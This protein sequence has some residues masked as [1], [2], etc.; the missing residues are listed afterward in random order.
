MIRTKNKN[1]KKTLRKGPPEKNHEK[2]ASFKYPEGHLR[3]MAFIDKGGFLRLK[4]ID[5][6]LSAISCKTNFLAINP[7]NIESERKMVEEDENYNPQFE[8]R[9]YEHDLD[10]MEDYLESISQQDS[11]MGRILEEKRKE[12]IQFCRLFKARGYSG[13]TKHS[14][15]IYGLPKEELC[16]KAKPTLECK[17]ID[18]K[19]NITTENALDLL[20]AELFH[21]G[22]G[23]SVEAKQ[24]S[25]SAAVLVSQRKIFLKKGQLFS[26]HYINRLIFHEIGTHVLRAENGKR[27]P[28][29]VFHYGL[30][31]Y[32]GTEEGLAVV[33]EERF[34]LLNPKVLKI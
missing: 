8:Y 6:E 15:N 5:A 10:S 14:I 22:F 34:G 16:E 4:K 2:K 27:Q 20:R 19:K 33:N 25:S 17:E 1:Q 12:Y 26:R 21:Y 30:P 24:M 32:L 31:H 13:F 9:P 3:W 23:Y 18:I 11:Y 28:F 29:K 7:K